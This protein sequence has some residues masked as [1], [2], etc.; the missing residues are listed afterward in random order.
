MKLCIIR[1][2]KFSM[3]QFS[4]VKDQQR[5][6][7]VFTFSPFCLSVH[8]IYPEIPPIMLTMFGKTPSPLVAN[9]FNSFVRDLNKKIM[10]RSIRKV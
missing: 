6:V 5:Y 10:F 3:D 8:K 9:D 4:G 7:R 1:S 2:G